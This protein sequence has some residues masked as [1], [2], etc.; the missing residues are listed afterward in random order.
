MLPNNRIAL[1]DSEA[2]TF[3]LLDPSNAEL[4][5]R[6]GGAVPDALVRARVSAYFSIS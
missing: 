4:G 2:K 1:N 3:G 5:G 6:R